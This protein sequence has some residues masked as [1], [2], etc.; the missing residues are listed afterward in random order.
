MRS[1]LTCVT[2][3]L[4][5][6]TL[7]SFTSVTTET[8]YNKV[9]IDDAGSYHG[10]LIRDRN[11]NPI[12]TPALRFMRNEYAG[13]YP[14]APRVWYQSEMVGNISH[15]ALTYE[16]KTAQASSLVGLTPA[17]RKITN[18]ELVEGR[19]FGESDSGP[20]CI[21]PTRLAGILGIPSRDVGR[22][23]VTIIGTECTL[24][25]LFDAEGLQDAVDID[26]EPLTPI[27]R[28]VMAQ[29]TRT[30]DFSA[31]DEVLDEYIHYDAGQV[32]L[33]PYDFARAAGGKL[34]SIAINIGDPK[35][36]EEEIA[37]LIERVELNLYVRGEESRLMSGL[38]PVHIASL[39]VAEALVY[40]VI[41]AVVGYLVCQMV[42][43]CVV[44][45]GLFAEI[46]LNYSSIAA[47][48]ATVVVML[49]VLASTIY[50]AVMA[51]RLA[52][53]GI[54]RRWKLV[55]PKEGIFEIDLPF[56]SAADQVLGLNTFLSEYI[57]AHVEYSTGRFSADHV[58][59]VRGDPGP[60][61]EIYRLSSTVW[62]APY[63]LG[64]RERFTL[65]SAPD[66]ETEGAYGFVAVI[67]RED[68]D[69]GAWIRL[70]RSFLT[71]LRQQFLLWRTFEAVTR[72]EYAIK[73]HELL[74]E[75]APAAL[76]AFVEETKARE[77]AALDE[78]AE[79]EKVEAG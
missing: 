22:A 9:D 63:D 68:G 13:K 53:P 3:I 59:L 27:D 67:A 43:K 28:Q 20:T 37:D 52:T 31:Q 10:F 70:T 2:L 17:E 41:G 26:D 78:L 76:V 7:M 6:F 33:V 15:V 49:T 69:E 23:T 55:D 21:L 5:T 38:A 48:G 65:V 32:A 62:I 57:N 42:A 58:K 34:Q 14:V 47:V 16:G 50:P 79:R 19:W 72:A 64:V 24:I 56:S 75:E 30:G 36:V 45:F 40:A 60:N 66:E 12:S 39:F 25:G 18:I 51:G 61:G 46:S 71:V 73:G 29:R 77:A 1:T 54:D 44:A 8:K 11:W 4:L 74:G 35:L